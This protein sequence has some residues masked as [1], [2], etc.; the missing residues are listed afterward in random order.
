M[1]PHQRIFFRLA[2][3]YSLSKYLPAYLHMIDI[4]RLPKGKVEAY[5]NNSRQKKQY[6]DKP[7]PYFVHSVSRNY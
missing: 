6:S 1:H 4:L 3:S 7:F 5:E 2:I